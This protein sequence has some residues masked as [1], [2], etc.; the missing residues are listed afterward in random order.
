MT[1]ESEYECGKAELIF[2]GFS[3]NI[4]RR[5][6]HETRLIIFGYKV[7]DLEITDEWTIHFLGIVI[8]SSA[9]LFVDSSFA[10]RKAR[11]G[12]MQNFTVS[13]VGRRAICSGLYLAA[14]IPR[15]S[16]CETNVSQYAR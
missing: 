5:N 13:R 2:V 1:Y 15:L 9:K 12:K 6:K 10:T 14:R 16:L 11:K 4:L 7:Y 8:R 3:S